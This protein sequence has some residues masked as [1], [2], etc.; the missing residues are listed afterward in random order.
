MNNRRK[1]KGLAAGFLFALAAF[2][3]SLLPAFA[4]PIETLPSARQERVVTV[5]DTEEL[6]N[7][8]DSG[9]TLVL[10]PGVYNITEYLMS[11]KNPRKWNYESEPEAGLYVRD[12]FD[13]PEMVA[14]G[15]EDIMLISADRNDPASIVVEP[16]Y[17]DVLSFVDCKDI[18][19]D[20]V[21]L[22]HTPDKG[23]CAGDVLSLEHCEGIT[24]SSCELYGCG[25]YAFTIDSCDG[26]KAMNCDIHDC[27]YGCAVISS[28]KGVVFSHCDFHDCREFTMFEIYG[29]TADFI[30]CDFK[31]LSGEFLSDE[32]SDITF[33]ACSFDS[34]TESEL[35]ERGLLA[36]K[37]AEDLIRFSLTNTNVE[38]KDRDIL[39]A[40]GNFYTIE[41][42]EEAKEAWP[43]LSGEIEGL[44]SME[45]KESLDEISGMEEDAR[46][47]NETAYDMTF[48]HESIFIPMRA[49]SRAFSYV[50]IYYDFL[51]GAHGYSYP[52]SKNLDTATGKDILLSEVIKDAEK[53]SDITVTELLKQ[54]EDLYDY[55]GGEDSLHTEEL[56]A[57]IKERLKNDGE[58]LCWALTYDGIRIFF[59]DY[60][61]GSYAAGSRDVLIRFEDHPEIFTD[62]F[63]T[64][65]SIN[66]DIS[67]Q[68]TVKTDRRQTL[69]TK[70]SAVHTIPL[71]YHYE[72]FDP[73]LKP[74]E[75]YG[76]Y[77][78]VESYEADDTYPKLKKSLEDRNSSYKADAEALLE[79]LEDSAESAYRD[80]GR[81]KYTTFR[82]GYHMSLKRADENIV[83]FAAHE[84]N[85]AFVKPVRIT[86]G[87]NIDTGTGEDI[88]LLDVTEDKEGL[89][90]AFE[91]A[92]KKI[93][94][95]KE[96]RAEITGVFE[97][98]LEK[99][100]T[101]SSR[102]LS[103]CTGYEGIEIYLNPD[104]NYNFY[105][106]TDGPVKVFISYKD[107]PDLFAE[108]ITKVPGSYIYDLEIN[109]CPETEYID[110]GDE[111][112]NISLTLNQTG[113][114]YY[115]GM[116]VD[117]GGRRYDIDD[118]VEGASAEAY[119][120]R[121]YDGLFFLYLCQ[122]TASGYG[123][124]AVYSLGDEPECVGCVDGELR[125][126]LSEPGDI[127]LKEGYTPTSVKSF[128]LLS[129]DAVFK[130][131]TVIGDFRTGWDGLPVNVNYYLDYVDAD[132][133]ITAKKDI[134]AELI[135][136]NG[137]TTEETVI[138]KGE[139]LKPVQISEWGTM[140]L[141]DRD[142]R[143]LRINMEAS[144]EGLYSIQ[145]E[146]PKEWFEAP[147]QT[148]NNNRQIK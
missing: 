104:V 28:T 62:R 77:S 11:L 123:Y 20:S 5:S 39:L 12:E 32:R 89:V 83:S 118:S 24:V 108:R 122:K 145:G 128:K 75:D 31:R 7:A 51:G 70:E 16:R 25:T 78:F 74:S 127:G 121:D 90:K 9:M 136:E 117:F 18:T 100:S 46:Y 119:I 106:D 44:N 141:S 115:N 15:F 50:L 30:D 10:E 72:E 37:E 69:K 114:G 61:M 67:R 21:S 58:K 49:D 41:L 8:F 22:G 120:V 17:A 133:E 2:N 147:A 99:D 135:D 105:G 1:L 92:L 139:A 112:K 142:D 87:N 38:L 94:Y 36:G 43:A 53:L 66:Y 59:E 97:T 98:Q 13:G 73:K 113:E 14:K 109:T 40:T 55:F 85:D 48:D 146:D 134:S 143:Q 110:A 148:G 95:D 26:I 47:M 35:S 138:P 65:S 131:M 144:E 88:G 124:I 81:D 23:S 137:I 4:A 101:V 27:T 33:T 19:I 103:W 116:T 45:K 76:Y 130:S 82:A 86:I 56:A 34:A 111:L 29:S 54:N 79:V 68:M 91:E 84:D 42:D 60:A 63:V 64:D 3:F 6:I 93:F 57:D 129:R 96:L 52:S 126:M 102:E 80:R 132:Y 140:I 107:N 125:F 71:A